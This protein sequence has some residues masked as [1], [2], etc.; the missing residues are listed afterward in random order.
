MD[1]PRAGDRRKPKAHVARETLKRIPL[2][3]RDHGTGWRCTCLELEC[4]GEIVASTEGWGCSACG[5]RSHDYSALTAIAE[6]M[7]RHQGRRL[8]CVLRDLAAGIARQPVPRLKLYRD[9]CDLHAA[10]VAGL[11]AM[12][13]SPA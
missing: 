8:E 3:V 1:L 9:A 5:A 7:M 13:D 11:R 4:S 12:G 6:A 10:T 2:S